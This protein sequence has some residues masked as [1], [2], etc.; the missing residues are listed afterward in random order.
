MSSTFSLKILHDDSP[1]NPFTEWDCEPPL[2]YKYERDTTHYQTESTTKTLLDSLSEQTYSRRFNT[3]IRKYDLTE[4]DYIDAKE[5]YGYTKKEW[6][7]EQ[8]TDDLDEL[9][10]AEYACELTN[11]P[12]LRFDSCGYSQ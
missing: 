4:E 12:Y 5:R 8:L 3:I 7:I 1:V 10:L 11:T 6:I 9:S 2:M